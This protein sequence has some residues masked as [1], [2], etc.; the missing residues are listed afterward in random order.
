MVIKNHNKLNLIIIRRAVWQKLLIDIFFCIIHKEKILFFI[1]Y[2]KTISMLT[3][4]N[5]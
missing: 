1:Y 4:F 3:E 2:R 5:S